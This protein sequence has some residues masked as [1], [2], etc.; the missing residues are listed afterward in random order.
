LD[1]KLDAS[2][3]QVA[4]MSF[5]LVTA[6]LP[7]RAELLAEM[8][9]SVSQQTLAPACHVVMRDDGRGFVGTVNRAVSLVDTDYF[10]LVDDD[11]LLLPNH[12]ETLSKNI[13]ETTD[14]LWTW[15]DVQGRDWNPNQGYEPGKL[16][17]ENYISSN[18]VMRTSLWREMGGYRDG[19][20]HPDWDM[21]KR[22]ESAN[23][24]FVNIPE[25]TWV[26]RF[27]GKN[28]SV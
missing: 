14:I 12:V 20:G 19:Y 16:Q 1:R 8:L 10:C 5:T 17:T 11:D 23:A 9:T 28:M 25:V 24:S 6:T 26:Y 27:H 13:T 22:C 3:T 4:K 21:L 15:T 18:M 7:S 2:S